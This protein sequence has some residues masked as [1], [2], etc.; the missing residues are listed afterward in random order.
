LFLDSII[1]KTYDGQQKVCCDDKL[2][3]WKDEILEKFGI[4]ARIIEFAAGGAKCYGLKVALPNG[5]H[6]TEVRAKGISLKSQ[7]ASEQCSFDEIKQL[8]LGNTDLLRVDQSNIVRDKYHQLYSK[9]FVK[10]VCV[11][12]KR[13]FRNHVSVPFGYHIANQ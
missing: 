9:S 2:G 4:G 12:T 3:G 13:K 6:R 7:I 11:T 5:Q 10:Q 8:V 1:Y